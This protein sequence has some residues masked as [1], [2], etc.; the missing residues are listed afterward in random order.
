VKLGYVFLITTLLFCGINNYLLIFSEMG[1]VPHSVG[2]NTIAKFGH[3]A[4]LVMS[5][6]YLGWLF[7]II[8]FVLYLFNLLDAGITWIV[9]YALIHRY[10]SHNEEPELSVGIYGFFPFLVFAVLALTVASFFSSE[11]GGFRYQIERGEYKFLIYFG[12]ALVAGFIFR[13]ILM[14]NMTKER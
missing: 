5:I 4:I 11:F 12:V 13:I 10:I 6:W 3:L 8:F 14:K 9:K 2:Y 1:K 7:G